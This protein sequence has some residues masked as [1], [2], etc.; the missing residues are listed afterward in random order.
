LQ[1]NQ[2]TAVLSDAKAILN[3]PSKEKD[4]EVLCGLLPRC[5]I[6]RRRD[7]LKELLD[8]EKGL[9]STVKAE[10]LRYIEG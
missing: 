4:L 5:V 8:T 6:E 10:V 2:L 1:F 9:S 7:I 3:K